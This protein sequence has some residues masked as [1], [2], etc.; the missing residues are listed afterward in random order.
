MKIISLN[1]RCTYLKEHR[2]S[3][4][5]S[6]MGLGHERH[7][8]SRFDIGMSTGIVLEEA[9]LR[10]L[11]VFD[12]AATNANSIV[13]GVRDTSISLNNISLPRRCQ[14]ETADGDRRTV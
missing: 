11:D 14:I 8:R 12:V 10:S 9:P 6:I 1:I 5:A 4:V 2:N 3:V 13:L 7:V